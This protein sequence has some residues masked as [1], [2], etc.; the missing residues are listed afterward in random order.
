MVAIDAHVLVIQYLHTA[1]S[2]N[3][4]NFFATFYSP[5]VFQEGTVKNQLSFA[6]VR[7]KLGFQHCKVFAFGAAPMQRKVHEYFMSINMP[8][9][10]LYGLNECSG[11]H[12]LNLIQ[13]DGWRV[14]SCG[15]TIK[16]VQLKINKP[17]ENGE[18]EV[19]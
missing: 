19:S 5:S 4:F 3:L 7:E 11:P 16:G 2:V 13:Q 18:G 9:R 8:L 1:N 12:T 15:K 10:E 14:G 6:E 17:D